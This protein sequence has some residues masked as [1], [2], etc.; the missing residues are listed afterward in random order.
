MNRLFRRRTPDVAL[1]LLAAAALLPLTGCPEK[2][3]S[4]MVKEL[5]GTV[6]E[7]DLPHHRVKVKAYLEK[8]GTYET[9]TVNVNDETEIL[10]NGSLASLED[11]REGERAEG[12]VRVTRTDDRTELTALA[13]NIDRG[14]VLAAPGSGEKPAPSSAPQAGS[15]DAGSSGM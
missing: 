2:S 15:S 10:I 13:V 14:E 8:H 1:A 11:V 4:S 9:F 7:I 3:E 12:R 5:A 6:E